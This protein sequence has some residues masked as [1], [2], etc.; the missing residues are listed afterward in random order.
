MVKQAPRRWLTAGGVAAGAKRAWDYY[1]TARDIYKV[2]KRVFKKPKRGKKPKKK[3]PKTRQN[4]K[5]Y[6]GTRFEKY[7][8]VKRMPKY[9]KTLVKGAGR[10]TYQL[11]LSHSFNSFTSTGKKTGVQSVDTSVIPILNPYQCKTFSRYVASGARRLIYFDNVKTRLMLTNASTA[12]AVVTVYL[13]YAKKDLDDADDDPVKHWG[14][15]LVNMGQTDAWWNIGTSPTLS[16]RFNAFWGIQKKWNWILEGGET[17]AIDYY[18]APQRRING[19]IIDE[20]A[21]IGSPS[22]NF[23][24]SI[25]GLT[26]YFIICAHGTPV[27]STSVT[28]SITSSEFNVH[29]TSNQE[30]TSRTI[31]AADTTMGNNARQADIP[32]TKNVQPGDQD[33]ANVV[34]I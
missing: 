10:T 17:V 7:S 13:V 32:E 34:S 30:F 2:G 16:I 26:K 11:A 9:L 25:K 27:E 14:E 6:H 18:Y 1:N 12:N 23:V 21:D 20:M 33:A 29:W 31:E 8:E 28:D 5:S 22:N 19:Q 3:K 15:G 24:G 4:F